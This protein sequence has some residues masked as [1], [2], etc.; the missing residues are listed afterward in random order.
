MKDEGTGLSRNIDMMPRIAMP[1]RFVDFVTRGFACV[2]T[3]MAMT[4][5]QTAGDREGPARLAAVDV[6]HVRASDAALDRAASPE[7]FPASS[8]PDEVLPVA[9]NQAG[10]VSHPPASLAPAQPPRVDQFDQLPRL[11]MSLDTAVEL[12]LSNSVT[13]GDLGGRVLTMPDS[14]SSTLDP[15]LVCTDPRIGIDAALSAY[16]LQVESGLIYNGGGNII[17]SAFS[18]GQ[19]GVFAQ[20]QTLA[21]GGVGRMLPTGTAVSFGGVAGYDQQLAGGPFAALGGEI[22]HPLMRGAGREFN[23]IA[24]PSRRP[25][26]TAAF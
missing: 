12:A 8:T 11:P 10:A 16:D 23:K 19:F 22:R 25:A 5:C 3:T 9:F 20:P 1:H 21:K 17:N 15:G 26:R 4:G 18:S 6:S 13:I 24:G 14:V 7:I 2:V